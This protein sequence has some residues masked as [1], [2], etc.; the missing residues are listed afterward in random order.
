MSKRFIDTEL[1]QK[2]WFQELSSENKLLT[3]YIF[4]NC[5]SA[6]VWDINYRMA[7]FIIGEPVNEQNIKTINEHNYMFE[8]FDNNKIFVVD[9]I[10]FQYGSLS[11]NCKPHKPIIEKLKKYGLYE[12]VLKGYSKGIETLEEKEKEKYKEKE[13]NDPY[14]NPIV[15]TF[16]SEY[17]KLFNCRVFLTTQECNKLCELSS[18][19]EDFKETIP[20]VLSKMKDIDFGFENWKPTASWL[21]KDSNY[22]AVLNGSYDKQKK[23]TIFDRW[24]KEELN[25]DTA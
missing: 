8:K 14:I 24:R 22:T 9:F 7:Q 17:S 15:N 13:I 16:K 21:L 19:I 10:K 18:D 25:D 6:G 20:V 1:W 12:R 4:Q 11:E 2:S 5:D 23:E 3:L